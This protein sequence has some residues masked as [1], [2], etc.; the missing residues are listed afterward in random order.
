MSGGKIPANEKK[1]SL[2]SKGLLFD[3]IAI[4]LYSSKRT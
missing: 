4:G 3:F 2:I 1:F